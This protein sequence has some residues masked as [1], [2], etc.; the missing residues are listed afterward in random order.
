ML[1]KKIT[2]GT[3]SDVFIFNSELHF[4]GLFWERYISKGQ[5]RSKG[6]EDFNLELAWYEHWGVLVISWYI[7]VEKRSAK[8]N[9]AEVLEVQSLLNFLMVLSLVQIL[10]YKTNLQTFCQLVL[11]ERPWNK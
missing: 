8:T 7:N 5:S 11:L 1:D 4:E 9:I 3:S 2:L 10:Y 6:I